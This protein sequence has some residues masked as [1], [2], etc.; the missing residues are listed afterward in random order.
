M[1]RGLKKILLAFV[2]IGILMSQTLVFASTYTITEKSFAA[3]N[4]TSK[5]SM[6]GA[7]VIPENKFKNVEKN[8]YGLPIITY[9]EIDDK[10]SGDKACFVKSSEF[11]SEMEYLASKGYTTLTF[12][13][14]KDY[15]KF[16]NPIIITFDDGHRNVYTNAYPILK[17]YKFK[18]V[19]FIIS[20]YIDREGYLTTNQI[21]EMSDIIS[22]QSHTANHVNLAKLSKE[23]IEKECSVSKKEI[24]GVTGKKVTILAYPYGQYDDRVIEIAKKYY[25]YCATVKYGFNKSNDDP[26]SLKRIGGHRLIKL[27]DFI[28]YIQEVI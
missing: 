3:G 23:E 8:E 18:A 14:I 20:K 25:N 17:K 1:K 13:N 21:K 22:F 19:I 12:D 5:A 9:H 28:K 26:Y 4:I 2:A 11:S 27:T 16:K 10:I 7:L 6:T 15:H 24:E